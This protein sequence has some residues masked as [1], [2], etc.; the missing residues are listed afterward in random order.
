MVKTRAIA[1][2]RATAWVMA[3]VC[4]M[5]RVIKLCNLTLVMMSF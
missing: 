1:R 4:T 3:S 2:I 5:A